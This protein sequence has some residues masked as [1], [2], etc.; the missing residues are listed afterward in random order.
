MSEVLRLRGRLAELKQQRKRHEIA[1]RSHVESIRQRLDPYAP[2]QE[3]DTEGAAELA[4]QL[5]A[6]QIEL[7]ECLAL[8]ASIKRELGE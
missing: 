2:P 4:V 3:I 1:M 8:I 7:K 5:A 6:E